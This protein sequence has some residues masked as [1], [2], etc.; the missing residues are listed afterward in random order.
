MLLCMR[1]LVSHSRFCKS[2]QATQLLAAAAY[3]RCQ[4]VPLLSETSS[5]GPWRYQPQRLF[6]DGVRLGKLHAHHSNKKQTHQHSSS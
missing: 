5:N 2:E 3:L 1:Y 4:L 6:Q